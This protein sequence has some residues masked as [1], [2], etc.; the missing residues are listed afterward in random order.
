[1]KIIY[2]NCE[3]DCNIL[4]NPHKYRANHILSFVDQSSN[5]VAFHK[6]SCLK[7]C[8]W[9]IVW[10]RRNA[11]NFSKKVSVEQSGFYNQNYFV[12]SS[13]CYLFDQISSLTWI[14]SVGTPKD[15][16]MHG[17]K[18]HSN[19]LLIREIPRLCLSQAYQTNRLSFLLCLW[20]QP[21]QL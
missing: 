19:I 3:C 13:H 16:N 15:K 7:L 2:F 12:P 14:I 6:K 4:K 21:K 20:A 5:Q 1:M 8:D 10:W 11:D 18:F 9:M 17:I